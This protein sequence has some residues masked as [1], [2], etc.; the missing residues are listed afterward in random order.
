MW[1][2]HRSGFLIESTQTLDFITS[3]QSL[4]SCMQYS[5]KSKH[6]PGMVV[7]VTPALGMGRQ[8]GQKFKDKLSSKRYCTY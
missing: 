1:G 6:D 5:N 3:K 2:K 7:L 4:L 8:K